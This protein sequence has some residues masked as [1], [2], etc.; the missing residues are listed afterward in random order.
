[1]SDDRWEIRYNIPYDNLRPGWQKVVGKELADAI[2]ELGQLQIGPSDRTN[3][4]EPVMT[5]VGFTGTR[6]GMTMEQV[7]T[8]ARSMAEIDGVVVFHH[9]DCVGADEIAH[10][11]CL[12]M[13]IPSES[14]PPTNPALRANVSN[15][16]KVHKPKP[17]MARN[18]DI[19]NASSRLFAC[20]KS[21]TGRSG[22]TWRTVEYATSRIPVTIIWPGGSTLSSTPQ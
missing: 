3:V 2:V 13:G 18:R 12:Q 6:T 8:F 20:P 15:A 11:I 14:H 7:E 5:H 17:Y 9:G 19:V 16:L 21:V 10:N 22:G 1:V 4:L